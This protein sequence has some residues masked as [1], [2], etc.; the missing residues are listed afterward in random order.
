MDI[1]LKHLEGDSW[2]ILNVVTYNEDMMVI[3]WNH[4]PKKV[5][6]AKDW[7]EAK[8]EFGIPHDIKYIQFGLSGSGNGKAWIDNVVFSKLQ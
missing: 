4:A 5:A 2:V 6:A 7:V 1:F 3:N 8:K